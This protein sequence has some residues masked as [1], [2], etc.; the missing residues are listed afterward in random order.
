MADTGALPAGPISGVVIYSGV[1]AFPG[2]RNI[3]GDF[4][5]V[6]SDGI[7]VRKRQSIILGE[8]GI[9]GS[10]AASVIFIFHDTL[11][12]NELLRV[13]GPAGNEASIFVS[14]SP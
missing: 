2:G 9:N 8:S 7:A 11:A 10:T 12:A 6:A 14:N 1:V 4:V 13:Y 3:R 5:H